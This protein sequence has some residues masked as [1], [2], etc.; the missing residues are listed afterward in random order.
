MLPGE[1]DP[2]V[3]LDAGRRDED[4]KDDDRGDVERLAAAAFDGAGR[5]CGGNAG[6]RGEPSKYA[7]LS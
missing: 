3:Y 5:P 1:S 6:D 4:E 7:A 2:A